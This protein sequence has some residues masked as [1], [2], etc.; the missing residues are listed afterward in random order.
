M[1]VEEEIIGFG[2]RV[3]PAAG[4]GRRS[5]GG[6]ARQVT[7]EAG[8]MAVKREGNPAGSSN[9]LCGDVLRVFGVLKVATVGQIQQI[10]APYLS[11]RHSDK[12]M[13]V[14][15]KQARTASH[16]GALSDLRKQGLAENGGQI[17]GGVWVS[18]F[19]TVV[20]SMSS[21][22]VRRFTVTRSA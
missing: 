15:R 5:A 3:P 10:A 22:T 14:K 16:T 13:P 18:S 8:L 6:R 12:P 1:S 9:N 7:G 20:A 21:S 2:G 19:R 17:L 11:Y 4:R